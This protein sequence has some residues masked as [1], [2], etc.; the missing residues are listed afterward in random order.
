MI[1]QVSD[2]YYSKPGRPGEWGIVIGWD[3]PGLSATPEDMPLPIVLRCLD[4]SYGNSFSTPVILG[5]SEGVRF[6]KAEGQAIEGSRAS[7]APRQPGSS[8]I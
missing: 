2:L 6:H 3:F 8:I 4:G 1:P 5:Y 7:E